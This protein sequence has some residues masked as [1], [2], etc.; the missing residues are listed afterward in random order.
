MKR[1]KD[2]EFSIVEPTELMSAITS[3]FSVLNLVL[4]AIAAISLLVGG[5]GIMNI[6]YV[7]VTER[8]SEIGLRKALGAKPKDIR[9]QFLAEALMLTGAGGVVGILVGVGATWLGIKIISSFQEGWVFQ[10]PLDGILLSVGV[11]TFIGVVFGYF[12][13]RKASHLDPIDALRYE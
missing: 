12:P 5:I 3:I 2:E 13:A 7:T 10:L 8:T 1:Y 9:S 4:V 11:S 6:M